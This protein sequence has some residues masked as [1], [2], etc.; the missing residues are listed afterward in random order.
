[1]QNILSINKFSTSNLVIIQMILLLGLHQNS[2]NCQESIFS[3]GDVYKL[4]VT[5]PGVYKID[6]SFIN[7]TLNFDIATIEPNKIQVFSDNGGALNEGFGEYFDAPGEIPLFVQDGGDGRFDPSDAIYFYSYGPDNIRLSESPEVTK[8]IYSET[9][10]VF[11]KFNAEVGKRI[12]SKNS[13]EETPEFSYQTTTRLHRH[14]LDQ[15]NLLGEF[16]SGQGS[17]QSWYGESFTNN[18]E[19]SF[20]S[21]FTEVSPI[22]NTESNLKFR[23]A[24][25]SAAASSVEI[26]VNDIVFDKNINRADLGEVE[27]TYAYVALID[28]PLTIGGSP[29][30][31]IDYKGNGDTDQA[32]LDYIQITS[33]ENINY[34]TGEFIF[35]IGS[36]KKDVSSLS[37]DNMPAG[38]ELWD[39]SDVRTIY[40]A[41]F[42]GNQFVYRNNGEVNLFTFF[43]PSA[44]YAPP[45]F[46]EK[47]EPQN[48]KDLGNPEF[49][50]V[51]HKDFEEATLRL[52]DHRSMHD[53]LI[54]E[55]VNV[56]EIYNEFGSGRKDITAIRN[57]V[58]YHYNQSDIFKYVLI[59]GD[60]SYDNRQLRG[61]P[62]QDF[63][64]VYQTHESLDPV[65]AF[66]T[67]DYYGI[68][69]QDISNI[70]LGEMQVAVGRLPVKTAQEATDV[71]NK[72]IRYDTDPSFLEDWKLD[73]G[74]AADDEDS[75]LH[76]NDT[77]DIAN[78]TNDTF[79]LFN[80]KKVYFD[81]FQQESTPGGPRYPDANKKLIENILQGQLVLT[82]LGHGGPKGW[83][84]ERVL[85]I[86][87]IAM[88]DNTNKLP[89]I[90]TATCSFTGFDDPNF[91]SAGENAILN[92]DGGAI[93]LF[94]TVRSVFASRNATLT[95]AALDVLFRKR[96]G[97]FRRL[98]DVLKVG[99]NNNLSSAQI[100]ENSRKFALI[101]DPT[102]RLAAPEQNIAVN[103]INGQPLD[104]NR[105][106]TIKALDLVKLGGYIHDDAGNKLN[107]FNG[108]VF[109]TLFDKVTQASTLANDVRS[110]VRSFNVQNNVLFKGSA[111]VTNGNWVLEFVIPKE[112][113][114]SFGEGRLSMYASNEIDED[115]G[116]FYTDIIIGGSSEN[117]IT[118]EIGPE[119]EIFMNDESFASGGI[120]NTSPDLFIK[121]EDELGINISSNSIGHDIVAI[122][123]D[124]NSNPIK[125]NDFYQA[126]TDDYR[127]GT[128]NYPLRN[129]EPGLHKIKIKAW[130]ICNN[131]SERELSFNVIDI[132]DNKIDHVY[133]YPNPFTTNTNFTF[134]HT[135]A[136]SMIDIGIGVY[137][138]SGKLVKNI[139]K[140]VMSHGFRIN[141][142]VWDG[143][144][145]YG[146]R[147]AIGTYLY[148]IKIRDTTTELDLES[149]FQKLVILK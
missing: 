89:L 3:S 66:P 91:V 139:E 126:T 33:E 96:E 54:T 23:F 11:I 104:E 19:Q 6:G 143:R 125:L 83:A 39:V 109:L 75:N 17:G 31:N 137:T 103:S 5:Q 72:I 135:F 86:E 85:Q 51:Y 67:D 42:N 101:G 80:Q 76:I 136:G 122:L 130:D 134:E 128:V 56:E 20:S 114:F 7:S 146:E 32:W 2:L 99:K 18:W 65:D 97:K 59:V 112:I 13:L 15:Q 124:D 73:I 82:Y 88:L 70:L 131:S 25:R 48:V 49:I 8:N 69:D 50:I 12:D 106:D 71:V 4:S 36:A 110:S 45:S 62:D 34:Q 141:D 144:D 102:I 9:Q 129:L 111:T 57:F 40:K 140:T 87:D 29:S 149:D 77:D 148:K 113:D 63:V 58:R 55:A 24:A 127:S 10:F 68:M 61:L 74:F 120:T 132:Q 108:K 93:A 147:L 115:A 35:H 94:T 81:S 26:A 145:D 116:G 79:N 43:N 117:S 105:I 121:L 64:P 95:E 98:G 92:P 78:L 16:L 53:P 133:N 142:I 84:Q 100:L 37:L 22:P 44:N 38:F 21:F 1:M 107:T 41:N 47:V 46:V 119:I 28:E 14:E 52:K 27:S 138:L 123:D 90:V 30:V 60:A 118:D